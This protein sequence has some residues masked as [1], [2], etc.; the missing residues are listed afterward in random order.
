MKSLLVLALIALTT[1]C[2]TTQMNKFVCV[3]AGTCGIN[4]DDSTRVAS[5]YS[6][7]TGPQLNSSRGNSQVM[8]PSGN[9]LIVRNASTGQV[10]SVI[11]SSK[12][13]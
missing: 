2:S 3:G 13:K 11:Q 7:G 6:Q 12:T 8:L 5:Y 10:M 9:Y 1:G 4:D